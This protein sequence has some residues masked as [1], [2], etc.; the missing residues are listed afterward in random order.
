MQSGV[1]EIRNRTNGKCYFGSTIDWPRRKKRHM[2]DL[3]R[4]VHHCKYLQRAWNKYGESS[5]EFT[6]ILAVEPSGLICAEQKLFDENPNRYN[7]GISAALHWLG[8]KHSAASRRKM[9]E[10]QLGKK[11]SEETKEK[12]RLANIGKKLTD[13][14]K[15]KV[16]AGLKGFVR[17][18]NHR[19]LGYWWVPQTERWQGRV[20]RNK[21]KVCDVYR[22]TE[23]EIKEAILAVRSQVDAGLPVCVPPPR[24]KREDR[25]NQGKGY[26]F[27]TLRNMFRVRYAGKHVGFYQT[28]AEATEKVKS[29]REV[30]VCH[31]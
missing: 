1:Y 7:K 11:H 29:L 28:E 6:F 26:Y 3:R 31:C 19:G 18:Q 20:Y 9:S 10:R 24:V 15:R 5:F 30:E 8:K 2:R 16:S 22:E 14:H 21:T 27:C 17:P 4:G 12:V 23:E 13:E 25:R